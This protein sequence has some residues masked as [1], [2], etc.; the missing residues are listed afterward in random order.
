MILANAILKFPQ[1]K[2]QKATFYL[3]SSF[4]FILRFKRARADE[5]NPFCGVFTEHRG[6]I[7]FI[8]AIRIFYTCT[9]RPNFVLTAAAAVP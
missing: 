7:S 4:K 8:Y 2:E 9:V 5:T 3:F 1:P 6:Y